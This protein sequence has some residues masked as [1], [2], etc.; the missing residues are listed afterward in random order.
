MNSNFLF[1]WADSGLSTKSNHVNAPYHFVHLG[2]VIDYIEKI[3]EEDIDILDI[4]AEQTEFQDIMKKII[5]NQYKAI[6]FYINTENLQN[7]I[8]LHEYIKEILPECKTI[9][10]GEM[11][12]YLPKFFKK[13][14]FDAI[15]AK[16]C[17]QEIAILDFFKYS[18]NGLQENDMRGVL[19]IRNRQ[20]LNC[21][22]GEFL[23]TRE[24]G[25]TDVSKVPIKKYFEMEKKQQVVVTIARGCPYNCPYCNAVMYYG[26]KERRRKAKDI[27]NYINSLD[28]EYFK[29]F[30][31]DFT[32]NEEKAMELCQ[33]L[34][35]NKKKIKWS[36]TT[37]PDLLKNEELIKMMSKSGCYKIAI[38][39]ES[40]ENEDLKSINKRYD[41][42]VIVEGIK[43]LQKYGI[44]YKALVMFGVP[45][46]TKESIK[47]T[48]D[49]LNKY[50]VNIRPTAYTP[51]YEMNHN[52]NEE[53]ISKY[54]KRTYYEGIPNLSYR[55]FLKLIYDTKNYKEIL[56]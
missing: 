36:C 34:I 55:D 56:G 3:I 8:K 18:L 11:P 54:D 43:L 5:D 20:L 41:N 44:E 19:L 16:E 14:N 7:T 35:N 9:A 52:M 26:K 40:V 39:I 31:P 30:A 46:Q 25:Y 38:G 42:K 21:K 47:Y 53:Q 32:L 13:T 12:I 37:R 28:Y 10:Y 50:N 1:I 17:D 27:V 2:E 51:F 49:F 45:N 23:E 24:W 33:E 6:A 48:L 4:E 22:K 29:F 15:V